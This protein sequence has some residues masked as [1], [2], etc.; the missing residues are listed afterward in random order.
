MCKN[1]LTVLVAV[2]TLSLSFSSS[3]YAEAVV[4]SWSDETGS[5][6]A[7]E[8]F[9]GPSWSPPQYYDDY[10]PEGGTSSGQSQPAK[11]KSKSS[12]SSGAINPRTGKFYPSV[13]NGAIDPSTGKFYPSVPGGVIDPQTGTFYPGVR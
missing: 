12:S 3:T 1:L 11:R 5:E 10:E 8:K 2:G 4:H 13:P 6:G 9:G 7:M